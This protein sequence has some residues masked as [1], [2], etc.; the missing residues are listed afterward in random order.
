[1]A[2]SKAWWI[3]ERK[4]AFGDRVSGMTFNALSPGLIGSLTDFGYNNKGIMFNETTHRASHMEPKTYALW[5]FWRAALAEQFGTSLDDFFRY[6]FDNQAAQLPMENFIFGAVIL[7]S[8]IASLKNK[9][10]FI[11]LMMTIFVFNF[12]L[13]SFVRQYI[14]INNIWAIMRFATISSI[15]VPINTMRSLSN[16]E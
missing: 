11:K 12:I 16:L 4:V 14:H 8:A 3:C 9:N 15:G 13:F 1:M 6:V 7:I 2:H 10:P 5:M